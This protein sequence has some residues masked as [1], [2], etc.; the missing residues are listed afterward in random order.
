ML[1][2]TKTSRGLAK[3]TPSAIPST[4][5]GNMVWSVWSEILQKVVKTDARCAP[6]RAPTSWLMNPVLLPP[7]EGADPL[8]VLGGDACIYHLG[9]P[10]T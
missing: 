6:P 4:A 2:S 1:S 10:I 7:A 5:N 3:A 8:S 9:K